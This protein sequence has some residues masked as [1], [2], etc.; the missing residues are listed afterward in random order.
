MRD[1][2]RVRFIFF[3]TLITRSIRLHG[4]DP[5]TTGI[6]GRCGALSGNMIYIF[7][8]THTAHTVAESMAMVKIPLN[9]IN[10]VGGLKKKIRSSPTLYGT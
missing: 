9:R 2:Q 8:N 3:Q 4:R 5:P 1:Q 6:R 10:N 7:C